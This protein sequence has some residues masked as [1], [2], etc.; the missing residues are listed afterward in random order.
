LQ[1]LFPEI[2]F[3]E[4]M[5]LIKSAFNQRRKVLRNALSNYIQKHGIIIDDLDDSKSK[6]I[7]DILLLIAEKLTAEEYVKLYNFLQE[8]R[9]F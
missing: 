2:D 4:Q 9:N 5:K 7:S 1:N 6:Y 3:D 8:R